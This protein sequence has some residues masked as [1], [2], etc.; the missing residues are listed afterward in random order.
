MANLDRLHNLLLSFAPVTQH[1]SPLFPLPHVQ[2]VP[3]PTNLELPER[4]RTRAQHTRFNNLNPQPVDPTVFPQLSSSDETASSLDSHLGVTERTG[5]R[6]QHLYKLFTKFSQGQWTVHNLDTFLSNS[7]WRPSTRLSS[8]VTLI[9]LAKRQ[10]H[11][12][13]GDVTGL[14]RK[15]K[16]LSIATCPHR[17][18]PMTLD[19]LLTLS[20]GLSP[21][22]SSLLLTMWAFCARM[23]SMT[24]LQA[25]DVLLS[26]HRQSGYTTVTATFRQG[27]TIYQQTKHRGHKQRLN[28][29]TIV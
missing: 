15:Y 27:K 25:Q 5:Q 13:I 16:L 2:L 8:A 4:P 6:R 18:K 21:D 20:K 28:H 19:D 22:L 11:P 10:L 7:P 12:F 9:A 1:S 24:K 17:A 26:P 23:T 14:V 29:E 3:R